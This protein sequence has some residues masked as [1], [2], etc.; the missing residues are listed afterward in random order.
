MKYF[1][2][3]GEASGDMHGANLMKAL[4][5]QDPQAEFQFWGGDRMQAEAS[6]LLKHYRE[7]AIMGFIEVIVKLGTIFKNMQQCK[8]QIEA[9]NPDRLIFIDYPGFNLR[10]AAWA[11][12]KGYLTCYYI[13]PKIWAWNE[14]RG[15]KLEKYIDR[16]LLIFPFEV[17][18]FKKWKVNAYYVGNPLMDEITQFKP[19]PHFRKQMNL[20]EDQKIIALLPGSRKQ[21]IAKILPM[22]IASLE[23]FKEYQ[24]I[25]AGAPSITRD[26]YT[27][28]LN[29]KVHLIYNDTYNLLHV[30]DAAI[31]C[32]GTATLETA[33]LNVPQLCSY[34]ANEV[35]YRIAMALVKLKYI[36]LVNLNLNRLCITEL[37]QHDMNENNIQREFKLILPGGT[38]RNKMLD[39]Y[40][41][42]RN[43]LGKEGASKKA[44]AIIMAE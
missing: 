18:Y 21:E 33:L 19:N 14:K 24:L 35:S 23:P 6:G 31:V 20:V 13:A 11:K 40:E 43:L 4:K 16:L 29:N 41:E 5:L 2:I 37:L 22:M 42:L 10:I 7:L 9:F 27:P 44:A 32:S 12:E 15:K 28:F 25:V 36:S 17:D 30:S 39:D 3:A 8:D 38:K 1:I 26:F 34:V